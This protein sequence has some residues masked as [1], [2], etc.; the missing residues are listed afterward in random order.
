MHPNC[1]CG[2]VFAQGRA[3]LRQN[4]M[5]VA[6]ITILPSPPLTSPALTVLHPAGPAGLDYLWQLVLEAPEAVSG[7]ARAL[8]V[9][10]HT[11]LSDA[12]AEATAAENSSFLRCLNCCGLVCQDLHDVSSFCLQL[13]APSA[14]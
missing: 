14:F 3:W 12:D 7:E 11:Q 1:A 8:L 6:S 9:R 5:L 13:V 10:S 2:R 4:E